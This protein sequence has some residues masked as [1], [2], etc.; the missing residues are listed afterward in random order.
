[1]S[2]KTISILEDVFER[3]EADKGDNESWSGYLDRLADEC[4]VEHDPNTA[5]VKNVDEIARAAATEVENR[6]TRR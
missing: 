1:M 3:L 6:M 2:R 5:T 4:G